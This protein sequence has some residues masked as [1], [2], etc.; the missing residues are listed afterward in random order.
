MIEYP[1]EVVKFNGPSPDT[2][3]VHRWAVQSAKLRLHCDTRWPERLSLHFDVEA[4]ASEEYCGQCELSFSDHDMPEQFITATGP[5]FLDQWI[6]SYTHALRP[7][8]DTESPASVY[9]GIHE[10]FETFKMSLTFISGDRYQLKS[11]GN[12][13]GSYF[14]CT[15]E[16]TLEYLR[17]H[18]SLPADIAKL[19][20]VARQ[21]LGPVNTTV[22]SNERAIWL[23]A[24]PA[25]DQYN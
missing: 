17:V 7:E 15:C 25:I 1:N 13:E 2:S 4:L 23:D 14:Q 8:P 22:N 9:T 5:S 24:K 10:F 18:D 21:Y 16:V 20:A 6:I 11:E 19:E 3:V 12:L